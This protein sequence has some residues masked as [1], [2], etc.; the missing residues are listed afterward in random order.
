MRRRGECIMRKK[1]RVVRLRNGDFAIEE[2]RFFFWTLLLERDSYSV[3][4]FDTKEDAIYYVE[5][6]R[7]SWCDV[8]EVFDEVKPKSR[9][10]EADTPEERFKILPVWAGVEE[11]AKVAHQANKAL[12]EANGDYSQTSW[13][14]APEWQKESAID[15]ILTI[16]NTPKTTP[17]DLHEIWM[18]KKIEE[19]WVYG[20]EKDT[21]KRTHPC[22]VPYDKLYPFQRAK[23]KVFVQIVKAIRE[24]AVANY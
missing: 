9:K 8:V 6:L 4:S 19:G 13:E 12:C 24:T 17:E 14:Y 5:T 10:E 20:E 11:I 18:K 15:T 22:I 16:F 2:K 1:F 21:E 3:V 7:Q 23:D